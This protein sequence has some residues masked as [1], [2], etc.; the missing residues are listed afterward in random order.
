MSSKLMLI[1]RCPMELEAVS[2]RSLAAGCCRIQLGCPANEN[3]GAHMRNR[4]QYVCS[5]ANA[6]TVLLVS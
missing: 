4:V 1:D 5:A 2:A 3:Q 6:E